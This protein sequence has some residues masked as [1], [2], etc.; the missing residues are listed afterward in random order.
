MGSPGTQ[1]VHRATCRVG[2][3]TKHHHIP[4]L[5]RCDDRCIQ[6]EASTTQKKPLHTRKQTM[7]SKCNRQINVF[8]VN[9]FVYDLGL[10]FVCICHCIRIEPFFFGRNTMHTEPPLVLWARA[11]SHLLHYTVQC[12]AFGRHRSA[13]SYSI[14]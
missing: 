12:V 13:H 10:L 3:P 11:T 4:R 14:Y 9:P 8:N 1:T 5:T 6:T 2:I 7:K